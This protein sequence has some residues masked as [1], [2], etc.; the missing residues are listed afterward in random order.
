MK[1][2]DKTTDQ[3]ITIRFYSDIDLG[4]NEMQRELERLIKGY[5]SKIDPA[6]FLEVEVR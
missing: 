1:F 6:Y 2:L 5:Q 4:D 3:V